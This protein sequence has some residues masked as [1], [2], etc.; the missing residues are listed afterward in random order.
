MIPRFTFA[1][2]SLALVLGVAACGPAK[3]ADSP[4]TATIEPA[5]SASA[6]PSAPPPKTQGDVRA[7][8]GL[9]PLWS[10][11]GTGALDPEMGKP[12]AWHRHDPTSTC[13]PEGLGAYLVKN[14]ADNGPDDTGVSLFSSSDGTILSFFTY[15]A[16]RTVDEEVETIAQV[17]CGQGAGSM[18]TTM[19]DARFDEPGR[20]AACAHDTKRGP[21]IEQVLV[22]KRGEWFYEARFS[23]FR[24]NL[25]DQYARA[26]A[27]VQTAFRKCKR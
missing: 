8:A 27:V 4:A 7:L 25:D 6:A 26:M 13:M 1:A 5:P 15:P 17:M 20:I 22:F 16:P 11:I 23:F 3:P 24:G 2:S 14:V 18:T 12:N 19:T 10:R 21:A 9:V